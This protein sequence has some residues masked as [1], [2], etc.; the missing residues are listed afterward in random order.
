VVVA[1]DRL[2]VHRQGS[3]DDPEY[4]ERLKAGKIP[5]PNAS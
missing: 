3:E 2:D 4:Q 5:A 1:A